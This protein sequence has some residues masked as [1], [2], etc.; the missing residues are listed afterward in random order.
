MNDA[1]YLIISNLASYYGV[2]TNQ[3]TFLISITKSFSQSQTYIDAQFSFM[4]SNNTTS[5]ILINTYCL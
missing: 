3:I 2:S 5:N 4:L 1:T